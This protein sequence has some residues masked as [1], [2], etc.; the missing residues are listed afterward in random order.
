MGLVVLSSIDPSLAIAIFVGALGPVGAY[1]IAAKRMSGRI[2]NS[3][4]EQLWA[5]SKSIRD[6]STDRLNAQDKEILQLRGDI[7]ELEKK[8]SAYEAENNLL[9]ERI[10]ELEGR[11]MHSH[12]R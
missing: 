8:V 12:D 4:A 11:G 6:W 9:K 10:D 5:E 1:L 2:A 3:D 7:T